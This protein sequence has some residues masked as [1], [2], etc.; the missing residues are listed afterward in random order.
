MSGVAISVEDT[1]TRTLFFESNRR[2]LETEAPNTFLM[3]ISFSLDATAE[4][5]LLKMIAIKF[6]QVLCGYTFYSNRQ[7]NKYLK[8]LLNP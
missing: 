1:M 8:P 4:M 6:R 5:S 2:R 7:L 3:L